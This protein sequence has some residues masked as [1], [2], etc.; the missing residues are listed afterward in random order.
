LDIKRK[1]PSIFEYEYEDFEVLDYQ[2]HAPIKAPV[3]V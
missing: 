2:C 3:A 1:P